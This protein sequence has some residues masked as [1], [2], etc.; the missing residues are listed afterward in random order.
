MGNIN[1]YIDTTDLVS[2][3]D[4]VHAPRRDKDPQL[5]ND[6]PHPLIELFPFLNVR[7]V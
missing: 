7:G 6:T 1:S 2:I 5:G 4:I 3:R